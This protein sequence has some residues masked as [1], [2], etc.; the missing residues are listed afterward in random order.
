MLIGIAIVLIFNYLLLALIKRIIYR[1]AS[2]DYYTKGRLVSIFLLVRY[3]AWMLAISACFS[4]LKINLTFLLAGSA[5]L[6]VGLGIGVQNIFKDIVSGIVILMEG[7]IK[8][9]D[10]LEVDDIVGR[11][12]N[13]KL[14]T[15]ELITRDGTY[16]I[17]PNGKFITENVSNWSHHEKMARF[18]VSVRVAYDADINLVK[19]LLFDI[20]S[21]HED[22][23]TNSGF[24]E[25]LVRMAAFEENAII[26]EI[27]FWTN[28]IFRV[29]NLKSEL[30][31]SIY[32]AFKQ[33]DIRFPFPQREVYIHDSKQPLS[34]KK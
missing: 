14:R 17:V 1:K 4:I 19:Q 7:T 6:L 34:E 5:A 26:F 32:T 8:V 22:V 31:F 33:N 27:F 13:I 3:L 11:V 16:I 25:I 29:E 12:S 10:V 15:T 23:I 9:N 24:K 20:A 18:S 2:E 30:R 28:N 21:S